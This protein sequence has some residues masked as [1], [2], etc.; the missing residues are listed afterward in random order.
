MSQTTTQ[1]A[2]SSARAQEPPALALLRCVVGHGRDGV[3]RRGLADD[4]WSTRSVSAP[5]NALRSRGYVVLDRGTGHWIATDAGRWRS[6]EAGPAG[7]GR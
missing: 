4:G 6:G 5:L 3:T 1:P 7:G 2:D